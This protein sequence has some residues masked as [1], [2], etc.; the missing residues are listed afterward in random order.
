[1]YPHALDVPTKAL[2]FFIIRLI[3][4][5]NFSF[6]CIG[7]LLTG[8]TPRRSARIS[9]KV[10]TPEAEKP[11]R[12]SSSGSQKGTKRKKSTE[13]DEQKVEGDEV[14]IVKADEVSD[15]NKDEASVFKKDAEILSQNGSEMDIQ[16]SPAVPDSKKVTLIEKDGDVYAAEKNEASVHLKDAEKLPDYAG[17]NEVNAAPDDNLKLGKE[18]NENLNVTE[19]FPPSLN[20]EKVVSTAKD[21]EAS[22]AA[23]KDEVSVFMKGAE[24]LSENGEKKE[25]AAGNLAHNCD[26]SK[27]PVES[28]PTTR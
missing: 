17:E 12:A 7:G 27:M 3:R 15:S 5:F 28:S 10:K 1:M 6:V 14:L 16:V 11:K 23:E 21:D 19:V 9:E 2:E 26:D 24:I 8:D 25:E 18:V 13:D 4:L 20:S 22:A